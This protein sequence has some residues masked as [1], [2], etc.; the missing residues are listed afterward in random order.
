MVDTKNVK[1]VTKR[2][3]VLA[4]GGILF[5][6][7]AGSITGA[8]ASSVGFTSGSEIMQFA[9][10]FQVDPNTGL[11]N[12]MGILIALG[13]FV[14]LGGLATLFAWITVKLLNML[15]DD[16]KQKLK[17]VKK[18]FIIPFFGVGA[19]T[20]VILL[21]ASSLTAFVDPSVALNLSD[22]Q[23]LVTLMFSSAGGFV[24][25]LAVI[26]LYAFTA[27]LIVKTVK[28]LPTFEK[29]SEKTGLPIV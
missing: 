1:K 10:Q 14:L 24:A 4:L 9:Q 29:W 11:P 21:V 16:K 12:F 20:F 3:L 22:P 28:L 6:A 8:V 2:T 18:H 7:I 15:T 5:F 26:G 25:S 13:V 19:L 27:W 23:T 17:I